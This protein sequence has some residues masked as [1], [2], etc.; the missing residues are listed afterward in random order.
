GQHALLAFDAA[1]VDYVLKPIDQARFDQAMARVNER[2]RG[3]HADRA[4]AASS[5]PSGFMQRISVRIGE[6][7]RVLAADSI[8]WIGANGNYVDPHV[9][10]ATY[11]HRATR[12]HLQASLDPARFL[13]IHRSTLVNIE[14]IREVHPLFHGNA[15]VV[16]DD[17]TRL[18]L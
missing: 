7:I 18:N 3:R 6:H 14:R 2:W 15:E 5:R 1:A 9:G 10:P 4:V 11:L 17:G 8:D 16:L 12:A 13:R